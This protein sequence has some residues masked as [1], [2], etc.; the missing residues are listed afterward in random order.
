[1]VI[2]PRDAN[3]WVRL[4]MDSGGSWGT[5]ASLLLET[6]AA[7]GIF[8]MGVFWKEGNGLFTDPPNTICLHLSGSGHIVKSP[9]L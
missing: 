5:E 7:S 2:I 3:T 6:L 8:V 9:S 1:M 4:L